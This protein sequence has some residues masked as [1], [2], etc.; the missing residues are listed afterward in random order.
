MYTKRLR[1]R[2]KNEAGFTLIELLAV[3]AILAILAVLAMPKMLDVLNDARNTRGKSDLKTI[4]MALDRYHWDNSHFPD[5]LGTLYDQGYIKETTAFANAYKD[6]G[7]Q[8]IFYLYAVNNNGAGLAQHYLLADPQNSPATDGQFFYQN[9]AAGITHS[10]ISRGRNPDDAA[11]AWHTGNP[12]L[13]LMD[14]AGTT[15]LEPKPAG[16]LRNIITRTDR[17]RWVTE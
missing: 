3:I 10:G 12:A 9:P 15:A 6:A 1:R 13:Q 2:S 17:G 16:S 7:G 8:P 11:Y 4:S 14:A 5:R